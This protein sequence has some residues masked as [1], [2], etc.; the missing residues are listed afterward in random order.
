[1]VQ[2]KGRIERSARKKGGGRRNKNGGTS[3][4]LEGRSRSSRDHPTTPEHLLVARWR[5]ALVTRW[6]G[7][8][9]AGH[10]LSFREMVVGKSGMPSPH[11]GEETLVLARK[12]A[13]LLTLPRKSWCVPPR[14]LE[15]AA[16]ILSGLITC[17]FFFPETSDT[18][19]K[20]KTQTGARHVLEQHSPKKT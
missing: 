1:M 14:V 7:S 12:R 16:N 20:N 18:G 15:I 9:L 11:P 13:C 2:K 10:D 4:G 19:V 8:S 6:S 5:L 17:S 3:L